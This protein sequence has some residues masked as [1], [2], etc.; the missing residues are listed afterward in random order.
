VGGICQSDCSWRAKTR[1]YGWPE[2]L[3]GGRKRHANR[4]GY[5]AH[6]G[7]AR[8]DGRAAGR[9]RPRPGLRRLRA[10]GLAHRPRG[11]AHRRELV[12]QRRPV[13]PQGQGVRRGP[14]QRR[15]PRR[16]HLRHQRSALARA[17]RR[18]RPRRPVPGRDGDA[19]AERRLDLQPRRLREEGRR[20]ADDDR[21]LLGRRLHHR[22]LQRSRQPR[23]HRR[24]RLRHDRSALP[25]RLA[26][27]QRASGR[28][29][30]RRPLHPRGGR[31]LLALPDTQPDPE[32]PVRGDVR[33]GRAR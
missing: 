16:R 18:V 12:A 23:L 32:R 8:A 20:P 6:P 11:Q 19:A 15:V 22:R 30:A 1:E 27:G 13:E 9:C 17:R 3:T 4:S 28:V 5:V 25:G 33:D 26:R 10:G 7:L 2:S 31:G 21:V 24:Q 29:L 14:R